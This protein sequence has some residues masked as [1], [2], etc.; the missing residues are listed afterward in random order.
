MAKDRSYLRPY[1]DAVEQGGAKWEALLW[2]SEKA[3]YLRFDA[4]TR[5]T[6]PKNLVVA[7]LGCGLADFAKWLDMRKLKVAEYIGVEG[8]EEL[9]KRANQTL[10]KLPL[11]ADVLHL[12]FVG[13]E[14][15]FRALVDIRKAGCLLFSGSLNTL[16]QKDA[17]KVLDRAWKALE[18]FGGPGA[19]LGFNFLSDRHHGTKTGPTGPAHRYD[20]LKMIRWA[21][22]RTP[23]VRFDQA[24]LEGHDATI[25]MVVPPEG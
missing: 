24:Y 23:I 13:D 22:D 25:A 10:A 5:L 17:E 12:D 18:R 16:K 20:T 9:A 8:V 2:K 1:E 3:Q 14:S 7:D 4:L 19:T 21:L 15:V 11:K 6:H